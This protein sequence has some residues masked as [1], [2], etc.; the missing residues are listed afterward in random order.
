MGKNVNV[1]LEGWELQV[2]GGCSVVQPVEKPML[3]LMKG[4][5]FRYNTS[6]KT[7]RVTADNRQVLKDNWGFNDEEF[8]ICEFSPVSFGSQA[9][10]AIPQGMEIIQLDTEEK[11]RLVPKVNWNNGIGEYL[12]VHMPEGLEL[13]WIEEEENFSVFSVDRVKHLVE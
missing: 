5:A 8:R 6:S 11:A 1:V 12:P 9:V 10:S 3:V 13:V 2:Y 7:W 4:T